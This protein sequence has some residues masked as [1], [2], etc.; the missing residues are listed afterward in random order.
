MK[1]KLENWNIARNICEKSIIC[2]QRI[3]KMINCHF[4]FNLRQ[5]FRKKQIKYMNKN[6]TVLY[7]HLKV[8]ILAALV[9]VLFIFN[10]KGATPIKCHDETV[11]KASAS[12]V[13]KWRNWT[14]YKMNKLWIILEDTMENVCFTYSWGKG[15]LRG[16][17]HP[18]RVL[19]WEWFTNSHE[20]F[21]RCLC[22]PCIF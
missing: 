15:Q 8:C 11:L 13:A 22:G 10:N 14:T 6:L 12:G 9:V 5:W 16:W 18:T 7:S 20:R 21:A 19:S 3:K 1:I 4:L 2:I 17:S